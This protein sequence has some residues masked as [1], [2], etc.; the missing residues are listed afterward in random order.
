MI[1]ILEKTRNKTK[2]KYPPFEYTV[3]NNTSVTPL[4]KPLGN[5]GNNKTQRGIE[6]LSG[7]VSICCKKNNIGHDNYSFAL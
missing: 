3:F 7:P 4:A 2:E 6:V 5:P 1:N